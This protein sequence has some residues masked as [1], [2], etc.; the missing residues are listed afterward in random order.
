LRAKE[1]SDSLK[2]NI[3]SVGKNQMDRLSAFEEVVASE[4][5]E[6]VESSNVVFFLPA[7]TDGVL[8]VGFSDSFLPESDPVPLATTE[9]LGATSWGV[10]LYAYSDITAEQIE[11]MRVASSKGRFVW[12]QFID[13]G[14]TYEYLGN[15]EVDETQRS[16]FLYV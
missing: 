6:F 14:A 2:L 11:G 7:D 16:A 5:I 1:L 4:A 13:P 3:D 12:E 10:R 15:V 9:Y 8:Y